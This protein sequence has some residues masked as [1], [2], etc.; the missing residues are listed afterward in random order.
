MDGRGGLSVAPLAS[1]AA[2]FLASADGP[3]IAVL[4]AGGWDTHANQGAAQGPLAQRLRGLDEGLQML[5]TEL[6]AVW[7]RD[8]GARRHGV[9]AQRPPSTARAAPITARR[10]ARSSSAAPSRAAACS[11]D[12]PGLAARDLHE[13]R[14][15]RATTDLRALF[16]AV[17][18]ERF[19][20]GEAALARTVFPASDAVE[21]LDGL[22]A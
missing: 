15:L 12:W 5:K 3:R 14:D 18:H 1:A 11:R 6:G 21:P 4:D 20:V 7:Q 16:K 17:L 22:T 8:D 19:G 9:R 13:G 10:A 2:R